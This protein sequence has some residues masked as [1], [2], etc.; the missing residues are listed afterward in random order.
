MPR[1]SFASNSDSE[2]DAE[3]PIAVPQTQARRAAR[4]AEAARAQAVVE[5]QA[6]RKERNRTRDAMLKARSGR[7]KP[8][9]GLVIVG[10][11]E[12]AGEEDAEARM[13]RA[14]RE[15]AE[16]SADDEI[17]GDRIGEGDLHGDSSDLDADNAMSEAEEDAADSHEGEDDT[18]EEDA[19]MSTDERSPPAN[20]KHLP[21]HLF[22]SAF[23]SAP[24]RTQ[25]KSK[26]TPA[27]VP[28]K[29][30]KRS[31]AL[32]TKELVV[33]SRTI[34]VE[35]TTP[36]SVPSTLPSRKIRKFTDRALALKG[37]QPTK[38]WGRTPAALGVLRRSSHAPAAR[39]VRNG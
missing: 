23:A 4:N 26:A 6:Q 10:G 17:E 14:L 7:Q 22:V 3:A 5:L 32:K 2:S 38:P 13:A 25:A 16:E 1:P 36:R 27:S 12:N 18:D 37:A 39:F 30:R 20:S 24:S 28:P 21:D 8:V 35:S 29:R 34:R 33:G 9:G 15:A 11:K 19:E 31:R